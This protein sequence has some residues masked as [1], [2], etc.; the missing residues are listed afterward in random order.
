MNEAREHYFRARQLSDRITARE[1]L[2]LEAQYQSNLGHVEQA[3]AAFRL[4]CQNYP[5]DV[6]ARGNLAHAL[7]VNERQEEAIRE[8]EEVSRVYPASAVALVNIATGYFMLNRPG[9]AVPYYEKTFSLE[10]SWLTARN[11]NHEYGFALA[12]GG[13]RSRAREVFALAIAKPDTRASGLRSTGLLD[14]FEGKFR[15]AQEHLMEAIALTEDPNDRYPHARNHLFLALLHQGQGDRRGAL[16]ELDCSAEALAKTGEP[17]VEL[18]ARAGAIYTRVGRL[19]RADTLARTVLKR[20]DRQ[21]P[22]QMAEL[23]RLEGEIALAGGDHKRAIEVLALAYKEADNPLTLA[24]L[25]HA[26]DVAGNE[27]RA[28]DYFKRLIAKGSRAAGWEP[29]QAWLE[30]HMRV[31]EICIARGDSAGAARA[32]TPLAD[33]WKEADASLPLTKRIERL[34]SNLDVGQ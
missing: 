1:R 6:A 16:R 33:L 17:L 32:L 9:K 25:C 5:D 30:A 19:D 15:K 28:I 20:V 24:S 14:M 3:V 18:V 23:H 27:A 13:N 31:A 29:Q 4:Y 34:R 21:S 26:Y 7:L 12:T 2:L 22:Q 8:Y 11:L 10:P